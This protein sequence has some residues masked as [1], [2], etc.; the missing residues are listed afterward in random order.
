MW[1]FHSEP[2]AV[3]RIATE[4]AERIAT[5]ERIVAGH[6]AERIVA[7]HLALAGIAATEP[8]QVAAER[9]RR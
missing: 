5:A 4:A 2:G 8:Y 9:I 7:G 1:S 6:L 3:A